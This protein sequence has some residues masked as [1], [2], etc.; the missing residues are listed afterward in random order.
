MSI[1]RRILETLSRIGDGIFRDGLDTVEYVILIEDKFGIQIPDDDAI[2]IKT[3]GQLCD[4]IAAKK[5]LQDEASNPE[6][7]W[8]TVRE[9]SGQW[10]AVDVGKLTPE[11]RFIE[12]LGC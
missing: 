10:F 2:Q 12:D 9:I 5:A 8:P 7:I 1:V 11:K 4:Y 3:L 6:S